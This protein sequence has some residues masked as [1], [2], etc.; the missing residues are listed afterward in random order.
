MNLWLNVPFRGT[1]HR[2]SVQPKKGRLFSKLAALCVAV[3]FM[4]ASLPRLQAVPVLQR[5]GPSARMAPGVFDH[6]LLHGMN[7]FML[8]QDT[9]S[10]GRHVHFPPLTQSAATEED[11]D[12]SHGSA[13]PVPIPGGDVIPP[14]IH[15]FFVGPASIGADGIE[16][17]PN[18][19]TNFRGFVALADLGGTATGTDGKT[20]NL[21]ADMRVIQGEYVSAD[22]SHHRGT[23]VL[24]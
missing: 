16:V 14:L 6:M 2:C 18:G 21:A 8:G 3:L 22:G 17:E 15:N 23:F 12:R 5:Q 9:V 7:P 24:I 11:R 13:E 4:A 1:R 19:I 10:R 20:Y